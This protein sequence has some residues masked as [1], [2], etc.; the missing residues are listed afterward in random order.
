MVGKENVALAHYTRMQQFLDEVVVLDGPE[1][2]IKNSPPC[3]ATVS[4]LQREKELRIAV[5]AD[6]SKA[7]ERVDPLWIIILLAAWGV[8]PWLIWI[9]SFLL[10][11]RISIF[12]INGKLGGSIWMKCGIDMGA[13]ASPLLFAIAMDPLLWSLR[14]IPQ[15]ALL[16]AYVD[17]LAA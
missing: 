8:S 14:V 16:S 1:S 5:F 6:A 12:R 10:T 4:R 13:G 9:V 11:G 3:P 7:F 15:V 17:D 2:D